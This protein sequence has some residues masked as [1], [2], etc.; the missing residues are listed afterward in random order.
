MMASLDDSGGAYLDE[1]LAQLRAEFGEDIAVSGS[2]WKTVVEA[3]FSSCL[4]YQGL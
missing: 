3:I 1:K 2:F 4:K